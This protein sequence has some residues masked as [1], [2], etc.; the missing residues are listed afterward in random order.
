M[1]VEGKVDMLSSKETSIHHAF[2]TETE[3]RL[4]KSNS[5]VLQANVYLMHLQHTA[6]YH[7]RL[8]TGVRKG[9]LQDAMV[10]PILVLR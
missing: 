4:V 6:R 3:M 9:S 2:S 8:K 10:K 1:N 7:R 5:T